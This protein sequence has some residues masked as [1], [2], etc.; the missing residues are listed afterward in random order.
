MPAMLERPKVQQRSPLWRKILKPGDKVTWNDPDHGLCSR[1]L[2]IRDITYLR[3]G[4][5]Q[6]TDQFGGFVEAHLEELS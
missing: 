6:I 3:G 2:T 4:V 1:T 5:V